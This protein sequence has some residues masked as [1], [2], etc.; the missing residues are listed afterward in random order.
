MRE[1]MWCPKSCGGIC[2]VPTEGKCKVI[3]LVCFNAYVN[4]EDSFTRC[5]KCK[6]VVSSTDA[7]LDALR[8]GQEALDKATLVQSQGQAMIPLLDF[9]IVVC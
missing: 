1:A 7:V 3:G 6:T 5:T 8:V 4:L 2:S 9:G